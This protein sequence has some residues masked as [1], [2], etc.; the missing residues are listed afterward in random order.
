M[1]SL[2]ITVNGIVQNVTNVQSGENGIAE[3]VINVRVRIDQQ[4][5]CSSLKHVRV[6]SRY[7]RRHVAMWRMWRK[8][9]YVGSMIEGGR[10]LFIYLFMFDFPLT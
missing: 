10:Y 3:N 8:K 2:K 4:E 5:Q 1:I 7:L 6:L 9:C